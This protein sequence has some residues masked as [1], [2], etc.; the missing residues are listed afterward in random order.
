VGGGGEKENERQKW[1][2]CITSFFGATIL[3]STEREC[4][5]VGVRERKGER[6]NEKER[7]RKGERK[8]ENMGFLDE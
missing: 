8:K 1:V 4:V 7:E 5:C 3:L 6:E 2:I